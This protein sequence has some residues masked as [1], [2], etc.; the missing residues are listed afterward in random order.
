MDIHRC[1][2]Y[3]HIYDTNTKTDD[4]YK[5]AYTPL[6]MYINYLRYQ[7]FVHTYVPDIIIAIR[8]EGSIL[9]GGF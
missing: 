8:A 4:T 7:E 2:K 1:I 6:F 5:Y 9:G 3:L